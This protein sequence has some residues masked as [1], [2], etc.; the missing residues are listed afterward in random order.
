MDV[1]I[2]RL[3][4]GDMEPTA[5]RKIDIRIAEE[6]FGKETKE[7]VEC[8]AWVFQTGDCWG[9]KEKDTSSW[10]VLPCFCYKLDDAWK[11]VD[12]ILAMYDD[13]QFFVLQDATGVHV[14]FFQSQESIIQPETGYVCH[15]NA[16]NQLTSTRRLARAICLAALDVVEKRGG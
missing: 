8:Q 1:D 11:V 4:D 16:Q 7:I 10:G 5:E 3:F 9:W 6:V 12:R 2:E 15:V 14:S 13:L